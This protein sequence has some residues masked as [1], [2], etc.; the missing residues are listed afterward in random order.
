VDA[1]EVAVQSDVPGSQLAEKTGVASWEMGSTFPGLRRW[2][3]R[4]D[5]FH[6][7]VPWRLLERFG[8]AFLQ[9]LVDVLL[10]CRLADAKW[11]LWGRGRSAIGE[12]LG[13]LLCFLICSFVASDAFIS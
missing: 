4:V 8:H 1:M 7:T 2:K 11:L 5:P 10:R 6:P 13:C 12:T 9:L 3:R